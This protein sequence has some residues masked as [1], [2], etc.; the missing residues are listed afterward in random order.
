MIF[1]QAFNPKRVGVR[2][3]EL[4][5]STSRTW[6]AANCAT[7]RVGRLRKVGAKLGLFTVICKFQM[8]F[9]F[10]NFNCPRRPE[11][12]RGQVVC[13]FLFFLCR[14]VESVLRRRE[15]RCEGRRREEDGPQSVAGLSDEAG[16]SL[17]M[18]LV[19]R[20]RAALC[21]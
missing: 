2:R 9:I 14:S 6:R 4:P 12:L 13:V 19:S 7:P 1:L 11:R 17:A 21:S 10:Y 15:Q 5:T 8:K 3:L 16:V 20:L 18:S